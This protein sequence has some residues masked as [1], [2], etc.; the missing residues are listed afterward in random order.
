MIY[1]S[2]FREKILLDP[3]Q[4][5]ADNLK[6]VSG[7]ATHTMA[8]WHL[9]EI[10]SLFHNPISITLIVGMCKYDGLSVAV[11]NGFKEL[12]NNMNLPNRSKF[13]CQYICDGIPVHSKLYLWEKAGKPL[14]AY[15]GSANYTQVAFSP[16]RGE[17]LTE[18][19]CNDAEKYFESVEGKSIYCNHGEIEEYITL[20]PTHP[21]LS[22]EDL[23]IVSVKGQGIKNVSLSFLTRDGEVGTKSGLIG[24]NEMAESPIKHTSRFLCK[25]REQSF[26][27]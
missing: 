20:M 16:T 27:L 11:H 22:A 9:T 1:T 3:I 17:I 24:D 15:M 10:A 13:M 18:C 23:P 14:C 2:N 7:Y 26:F 5:G 12:M 25:L 6:I 21:V 19:D 8:S 4:I